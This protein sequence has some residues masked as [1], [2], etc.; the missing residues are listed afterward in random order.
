MLAKRIIPCLDVRNGRVVKGQ[1][2]EQIIDV[3]DPVRLAEKYATTGADE[4]VF[5]DITASIEGR[6]LSHEFVEKVAQVINIPFTVGGGVSTLQDFEMVLRRGA[7][8]VSINTAA[9][10]NPKLIEAAAL[11][12]G[13]QCVVLSIDTKRT[14]TG[15]WQVYTHGGRF[16]TGM[17][18]MEWIDRATK[19]GV[20][21]IVLN[22]IHS[23]GM[24]TGYDLELLKCV[25]E[26]VKVP[27]IASGGAGCMQDFYDAICI[28][29]A[30]GVLAA[31]VFH[32]DEINIKTLKTY[33]AHHDI[34][35][36]R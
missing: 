36:R 25:C 28:G 8:K 17:D 18:V 6:K 31:S 27:V 14:Q 19:L 33:L 15:K 9:V 30:D 1:K 5:Y 26:S 24:K 16:N 4:L 10:Q 23:D 32:Y 12:Y 20:G 2:F 13:S 29:K 21:E 11:K 3:D 7:D 35:V 34:A 22:S